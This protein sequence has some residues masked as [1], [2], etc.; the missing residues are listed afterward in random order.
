MIIHPDGTGARSVL[1]KERKWMNYTLEAPIVWSP[2]GDRLLLNQV[3]VEGYHNRVITVD[4]ATGHAI[5]NSKNG[6][7]VLGWVPYSGK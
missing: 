7:Y 3:Q 4:L 5:M 2:E 6:E 1:E